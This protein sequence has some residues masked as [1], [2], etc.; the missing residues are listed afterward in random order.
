MMTSYSVKSEWR[1]QV[2]PRVPLQVS[3]KPWTAEILR[4]LGSIAIINKLLGNLDNGRRIPILLRHYLA[5][6]GR[7]ASFTVNHGLNGSLDGLI[8]VDLRQAPQKYLN[9]Y[10]GK[11]GAQ[12]FLQRWREK[13]NAA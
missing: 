10:L 11:E 6:N 5:L 4:S 13:V 12:V 1:R 7:F 8:L 3:G 2:K 9:R